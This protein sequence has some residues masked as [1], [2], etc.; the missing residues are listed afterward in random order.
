MP[1]PAWFLLR[2]Q[3]TLPK[4]LRL[5]GESH[6]SVIATSMLFANTFHVELNNIIEVKNLHI[7]KSYVQFTIF[8][9]QQYERG[10]IQL[11]KDRIT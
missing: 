2:W 6:F 9:F 5:N 4:I 7:Q 10:I 3:A 8:R 11:L 1:R